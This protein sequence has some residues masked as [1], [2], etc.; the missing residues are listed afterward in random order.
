MHGTIIMA[1]Y[2]STKPDIVL[3]VLLGG[4]MLVLSQYCRELHK[5][6]M[7]LLLW[8]CMAV[9]NHTYADAIIWSLYV[10]IVSVLYGVN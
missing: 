8:H 2:G 5:Q 10:G 1:L 7:A 6:C 4:C 3:K 9:F